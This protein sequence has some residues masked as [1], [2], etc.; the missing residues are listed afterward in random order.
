[1]A[2]KR[3][4]VPKRLAL[5]LLFVCVPVS[6]FSGVSAET[7]ASGPILAQATQATLEIDTAAIRA[8]PLEEIARNYVLSN[9]VK[10]AEQTIQK[11]RVLY[12]SQ[13]PIALMRYGLEVRSK[14]LG[15]V[16][17]LARLAADALK[18][19]L[20]QWATEQLNSASAEAYEERDSYARFVCLL[21]LMRAYGQ[22]DFLDEKNRMAKEAVRALEEIY[23]GDKNE[24]SRGEGLLALAEIELDLGNTGQAQ[25]RLATLA[26]FVS[27]IKDRG[28]KVSILPRLAQLQGR[29]GNAEAARATL[30]D[31]VKFRIV[32][33]DQDYRN[34]ANF[35][36]CVDFARTAQML[37]TGGKIQSA[38]QILEESRI[39]LEAIP[40]EDQYLRSG[41]W[42]K[43]V[44][45]LVALGDLD[46]AVQ[47]EVHITESSFQV[48][49]RGEIVKGFFESGHTEEAGQLAER[50]GLQLELGLLE[51]KAGHTKQAFEILKVFPD[52]NKPDFL[53]TKAH[54][55]VHFHGIEKALEWA[56][57]HQSAWRRAF[58][59]IGISDCLIPIQE[60]LCRG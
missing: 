36:N 52:S 18:V 24:L 30:R 13:T 22:L 21:S 4:R 7:P 33:G 40:V 31:V 16:E 38:W 35:K 48:D 17:I 41:A 27:T 53:Q 46:R 1:M 32:N 20:N 49:T 23:A 59:L 34:F 44:M 50:Y 37:A 45:A 56:V 57:R 2:S 8:D 6:S 12:S 58:A 15:M 9:D 28:S 51:A 3:S 10:G 25:T 55:L 29:S 42:Q 39:M 11:I 54:L 26:D 5:Y 19:G 14:Q 60:H 43:I 47:S